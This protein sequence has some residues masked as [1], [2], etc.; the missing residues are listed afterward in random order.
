MKT[1]LSKEVIDAIFENS[2]HQS[3]VVT[4]LYES[5]IPR[6]QDIKKVGHFP[7]T[8]KNTSEYIFEKFIDFDK[9]NHPTVISGGRWLNNGFDTTED[10]LKDFEVEVDISKLIY[11]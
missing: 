1:E 5:V 2:K 3:E 4:K 7:K 6:F 10:P 8:N 11:N 9:K